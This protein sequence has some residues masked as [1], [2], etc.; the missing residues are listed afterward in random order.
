MTWDAKRWSV[1]LC[2]E[3][4]WC[5]SHEKCLPINVY[6]YTVSQSTTT[7][8][9]SQLFSEH[10]SVCSRTV[11]GTL[12]VCCDKLYFVPYL[13]TTGHKHYVQC[14]CTS[15]SESKHSSSKYGAP[16]FKFLIKVLLRCVSGNFRLYWISLILISMFC[17]W[18][19]KWFLLVYQVCYG[20]GIGG[21]FCILFT[22]LG[23]NVLLGK[24]SQGVSRV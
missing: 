11:H 23:F 7:N 12:V 18:V 13:T 19:Y 3:T 15:N 2:R 17:R 8:A 16:I 1:C 22:F 10:M 4:L 24:F 5:R 21:Y 9:L 14:F 6:Q 20:I